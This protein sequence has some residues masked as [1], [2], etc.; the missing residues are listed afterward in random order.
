[1][2]GTRLHPYICVL[3]P[4]SVWDLQESRPLLLGDYTARII[5]RKLTIRQ[6]ESGPR[7]IPSSSLDQTV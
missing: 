3:D 5:G 7:Y 6:D 4:L 2:R 1:M